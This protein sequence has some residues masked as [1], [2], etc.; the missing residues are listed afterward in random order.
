MTNSNANNSNTAPA[1]PF[2]APV[3][4]KPDWIRTRAP[5]G[6]GAAQFEHVKA[7]TQNKKL[8]TICVEAKCPNISECWS[9]GTATFLL[10]GDICTR[11]CRFCSTKSA[12]NGVSMLQ[13]ADEPHNLA[14]AVKELK[15]DYVVLTSVDRDDLADQGA[16]HFA[17]CIRAVKELAPEVIIEVLI[18]DF[19][20]DETCIK[21]IVDA[22]PEVISHNVETVRE[23]QSIVRDLRAN[24]D[25]SLGV[26]VTAKKLNPK[27]F[28]KSALMLGLGERDEQII[29]TMDDLRA[30][31][32]DILTIGQYLRPSKKH[33]AIQNYVTPEKY[34][35]FGKIGKEKG[36]L[37]VAS[38]PFVR[39]SYK[40]GE[41]FLK[42]VINTKEEART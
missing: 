9:V 40:A 38:G 29:K 39:S 15:L 37:Y 27:V 28:T 26:L 22:G 19:R 14:E 32:C 3:L 24:Y 6:E 31:N 25:Q 12:R 16:G 8:H 41:F 20:G 42:N 18:P 1:N 13:L 21:T 7:L 10:M 5:S 17:T 30:I 23:L 2:T 4:P 35:E 36:F 11:Y 34:A 33:I